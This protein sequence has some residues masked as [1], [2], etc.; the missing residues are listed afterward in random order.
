[1]SQTCGCKWIILDM[2]MIA[3]G[4]EE[5]EGLTSHGGTRHPAVRRVAKR[6]AFGDPIRQKSVF[7]LPE[8]SKISWNFNKYVSTFDLK[9][10]VDGYSANEFSVNVISDKVVMSIHLAPKLQFHNFGCQEFSANAIRPQNLEPVLIFMP[11]LPRFHCQC[12]LATITY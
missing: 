12:I 4:C 7:L 9:L 6:K 3:D 2:A 5:M 10:A 1:M 8:M 11:L